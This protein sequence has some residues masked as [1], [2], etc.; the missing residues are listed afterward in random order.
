MDIRL[1]SWNR[2]KISFHTWRIINGYKI[3]SI[4]DKPSYMESFN[5]TQRSECKC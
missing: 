1:E 2:Y 4:H 3:R 5:G